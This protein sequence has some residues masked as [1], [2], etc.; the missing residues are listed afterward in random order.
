MLLC[1]HLSLHACQTHVLSKSICPWISQ[2]KKGPSAPTPLCRDSND[3]PPLG[4]K[5]H[6][7]SPAKAPS[8]P[9]QNSKHISEQLMLERTCFPWMSYMYSV[10]FHD[11]APNCPFRRE[12]IPAVFPVIFLSLHSIQH[13][14]LPS[15]TERLRSKCCSVF[16][17]LFAS[18]TKVFGHPPKLQELL[19]LPPG[20]SPG[21][22]ISLLL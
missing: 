19:S 6:R 15:P 11:F 4:R 7:A 5:R 16:P 13:S 3:S 8:R 9:P 22:P 14:T 1:S 20:S 21:H 10:A 17:V 18:A 12:N 2:R